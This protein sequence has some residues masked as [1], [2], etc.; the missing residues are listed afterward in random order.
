MRDIQK[1]TLFIHNI[2]DNNVFLDKLSGKS[3]LN[4]VA[5][6]LFP[7]DPHNKILPASYSILRGGFPYPGL[8]VSFNDN[9]PFYGGFTR[10]IQ[11][12]DFFKVDKTETNLPEKLYDSILERKKTP[13]ADWPMFWPKFSF[14]SFKEKISALSY[15]SRSRKTHSDTRYKIGGVE[16]QI[17]STKL[18]YY[19]D[20]R[21]YQL[22][23]EAHLKPSIADVKSVIIEKG[24]FD[25][26][27]KLIVSALELHRKITDERHKIITGEDEESRKKF[28]YCVDIKILKEKVA[29][30]K[31][32]LL[33]YR[34]KLNELTEKPDDIK[35][36]QSS[37]ASKN[38]K[39]NANKNSQ[40][41]ILDQDNI[42]IWKDAHKKKLEMEIERIITEEKFSK[43][44]IDDFFLALTNANNANLEEVYN[45]LKLKIESKINPLN[46]GKEGREL[47][48]RIVTI[49]LKKNV[50]IEIYDEKGQNLIRDADIVK[51]ILDNYEKL[52]EHFKSIISELAQNRDL[53]MFINIGVSLVIDSKEKRDTFISCFNE[54]E[55]G[56]QMEILEYAMRSEKHAFIDNYLVKK[57]EIFDCL[58]N[59]AL[60]NRNTNLIKTY[61][62]YPKFKSDIQA[63]DG[64][65]MLHLFAEIRDLESVKKL[66]ER[67]VNY[68]LKNRDGLT[69][70][71]IAAK[72]CN[73]AIMEE[74]LKYDKTP[75]SV[76]K[77]HATNF[78]IAIG[79]GD[80]ESAKQFLSLINLEVDQIF[81]NGI[82]EKATYI[83]LENYKISNE[84]GLESDFTD[85]LGTLL[86]K[87]NIKSGAKIIG[88]IARMGDLELVKI[89][90]ERDVDF[91]LKDQYGLI[92]L[93][94][95]LR[96]DHVEVA[97]ELSKK[98]KITPDELL[99]LA[100][101]S[102]K[103]ELYKILFQ[104]I[105]ETEADPN[106]LENFWP[107]LFHQAN[108]KNN[109][110]I[111]G[112]LIEKGLDMEDFMVKFSD[113]IM[114]T[115]DRH[116]EATQDMENLAKA[117]NKRDATIRKLD[118]RNISS[119]FHSTQYH[120]QN[121]KQI[122]AS[123]TNKMERF[124]SNLKLNN[125]EEVDFSSKQRYANH[126]LQISFVKKF[127][128]SDILCKRLKKLN[129]SYTKFF[130]GQSAINN[131][132]KNIK[133]IEELN[134]SSSNI[135][136][137]DKEKL[138]KIQ[139]HLK[140][141]LKFLKKVDLSSNLPQVKTEEY[142]CT[143]ICEI[144]KSE[145]I[146][147][148]N[149]SDNRYLKKDLTLLA[150]NLGENTALRKLNLSNPWIT[151]KID[152]FAEALKKNNTLQD[153][154]LTFNFLESS[155]EQYGAFITALKD[156]YTLQNLNIDPGLINIS[157]ELDEQLK[158]ILD[159]N[160]KI[161]EQSK[162]LF[163][164]EKDGDLKLGR[165]IKELNFH[166]QNFLSPEKTQEIMDIVLT[167]CIFLE[168]IQSSKTAMV[169]EKISVAEFLEGSEERVLIAK[170]VN[171]FLTS[172]TKKRPA[173]SH[174]PSG[175]VRGAGISRGKKSKG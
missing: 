127:F 104:K 117:F 79:E 56:R 4:I 73:I 153:L 75:E 110:E 95:A 100:L 29:L 12:S 141:E 164:E 171:D 149:I 43:P 102:D 137:L 81:V 62:K 121:W 40:S 27:V 115:D 134:F 135:F 169:M 128:D 74:I 152:L 55:R 53:S 114:K 16:A 105:I 103:T 71:D 86:K 7:N 9:S 38:R 160:K 60:N 166:L 96:Y 35:E 109:K 162:I 142:C 3:N 48:K 88:D 33:K 51:L 67:G 155:P 25:T 31:I 15:T 89:L 23:N 14:L 150:K 28:E 129:V 116:S 131:F 156:N 66:L 132:L 20:H 49:D 158:A 1:E 87:I 144:M 83:A 106:F 18:T 170:A 146:T 57:T 50:P 44:K 76:Q 5:T 69:P 22:H 172:V 47:F 99:R 21:H 91:S 85:L 157:P 165:E 138:L 125:L 63:I 17:P 34:L 122:K 113:K 124:F 159:R 30:Q 98:Q 70:L 13:R 26:D 45:S 148:L 2:T 118:F 97:L 41:L 111:I 37:F 174:E 145:T 42:K 136:D 140:K 19:D 94:N 84:S 108:E 175:S 147:D 59:P 139:N 72:N 24:K 133:N 151:S 32:A 61:L 120:R 68:N 11:S 167:N 65:T 93:E 101:D 64:S 77:Y 82:I 154:D 10:N 58:S 143:F 163:G 126:N 52:K 168:N 78:L 39:L 173:E 92:P 8:A 46:Y 161:S 80:L 107:T 119:S 123:F 6:L 130:S 112:F 36:M 54:L 90:L